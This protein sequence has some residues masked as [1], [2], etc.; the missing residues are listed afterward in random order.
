MGM[1]IIEST[2]VVSV[3]PRLL[4]PK[5]SVTVLTFNHGKWLAECLESIVTQKTNFPFE[6][7]VGDDASTDGITPQILRD[8]ANHYPDLIVPVFRERNING[9]QNFLDVM[10]RAKGKYIAYLDGDDMML[11]GK[12]QKQADFLDKNPDCTIVAHN[13][14]KIEGGTGKVI[15]ESFVNFK[16]PEKAGIEYLCMKGCYF[17]HCS[18]MY[19]SSAII[20][21]Y[22][23]RRTVDF[24]YHLEQASK[25]N[26]GYINET[27]G[28]WRK[29]PMT[30]SD[31]LWPQAH[32]IDQAY[33]DAYRRAEELGVKPEII[34]RSEISWKCK[35]GLHYLLRGDIAKF[36]KIVEVNP[37]DE[38]HASLTSRVVINLK[39]FPFLLTMLLRLREKLIAW[40]KAHK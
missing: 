1:D 39:A 21:R 31:P 16:I 25:G 33:F 15:S 6:V 26:I 3:L 9:T 18:K 32:I 11:P 19:R 23:D 4:A 2:E 37:V 8:Y 20:S 28:I 7:I 24:F 34:K 12:L 36:R 40:R 38:R 35:R 17:S 29:S 5:V 30:A 27:L 13:V 10:R 14:R 22:R